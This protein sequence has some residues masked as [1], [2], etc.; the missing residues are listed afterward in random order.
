[1]FDI[2][3]AQNT[4]TGFVRSKSDGYTSVNLSQ[5]GLSAVMALTEGVWNHSSVKSHWCQIA[6]LGGYETVLFCIHM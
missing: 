1:M 3:L 4:M 6:S 5:I 2:D